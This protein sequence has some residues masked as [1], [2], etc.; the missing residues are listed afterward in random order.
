MKDDI[1]S[2]GDVGVITGT[3]TGQSA[4]CRL[5]AARSKAPSPR[6]IPANHD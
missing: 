2:R 6:K 3:G 4:A 1:D 5:C